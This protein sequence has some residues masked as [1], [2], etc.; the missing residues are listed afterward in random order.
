MTGAA[1]AT[2]AD[3]RTS[4]AALGYAEEFEERIVA[5]AHLHFLHH[6]DV[7]HGLHG[8]LGRIRK[9][10]VAV[11]LVGGELRAESRRAHHF[12]FDILHAV[13]PHADHAPGRS[14][15]GRGGRSDDACIHKY[16][17][18]NFTMFWLLSDEFSHRLRFFG[19]RH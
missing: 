11:R 5:A 16:L 18:H 17:F 9:V 4:A 15:S 3:I 6:L 7:H 19:S 8:V 14:A 1:A 10:G 13:L 12:A 2:F